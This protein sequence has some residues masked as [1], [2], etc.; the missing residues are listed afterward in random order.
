M[1]IKKSSLAASSPSLILFGWNDL[2]LMQCRDDNCFVV[3]ICQ[4]MLISLYLWWSLTFGWGVVAPPQSSSRAREVFILQACYL[5]AF[6]LCMGGDT[7]TRTPMCWMGATSA[8]LLPSITYNRCMPVIMMNIKYELNMSYDTLATLLTKP[9]KPKQLPFP[10][11]EFAKGSLWR[12]VCGSRNGLGYI[13]VWTRIRCAV[14][15]GSHPTFYML[16]TPD[17]MQV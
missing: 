15:P 16:H 10:T 17:T 8:F 6:P 13:T 3:L 2:S 7:P 9:H 5:G 14:S 4:W 11:K 1:T 12:E